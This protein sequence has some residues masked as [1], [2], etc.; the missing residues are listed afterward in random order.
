MSPL[1]VGHTGSPAR[2]WSARS[3]AASLVLGGIAF[4]GLAIYVYGA[5]LFG[6]Q[7]YVWLRSGTWV[8]L[9]TITLLVDTPIVGEGGVGDV[10]ASEGPPIKLR[11]F[12]PRID[13]NGISE[14]LRHPTSWIGLHRA[15]A[16]M[17][18][19]LSVPIAAILG[20]LSLAGVA[21]RLWLALASPAT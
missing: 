10:P 7:A 19:F 8:P 11:R 4:G 6:G 5:L 17:L 21:A 14:W 15:T 9:P 12:V 13:I 20:G 18:T 3:I 2:T 16:G 1:S